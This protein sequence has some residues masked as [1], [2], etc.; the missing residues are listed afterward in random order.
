MKKVGLWIKFFQ[1]RFY[2][3]SVTPKKSEIMEKKATSRKKKTQL[4]SVPTL[5]QAIERVVELSR[6]SQMSDEFMLQAAPE[7]GFL[8]ES[9]GITER[10][11]NIA[12]IC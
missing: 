11:L 4:K 12:Q 10:P 7:I 2:I 9:Y 6:D 3:I 8:A 1:I 5:L